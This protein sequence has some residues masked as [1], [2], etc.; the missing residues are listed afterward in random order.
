VPL[1]RIGTTGGAHVAGVSL[2]A[3]R[4][5]HDGALPALLKG[6]L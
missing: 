4:A 6:E 3:L 5:A 2:D 1:R